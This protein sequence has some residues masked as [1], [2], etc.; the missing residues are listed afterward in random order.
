MDVIVKHQGKR[1]TVVG[2]HKPVEYSMRPSEVRVQHNCAG[3]RGEKV[4]QDMREKDYVSWSSDHFLG[5]I[6]IGID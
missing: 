1:T 3:Y 2:L 4:E 5:P 6:S